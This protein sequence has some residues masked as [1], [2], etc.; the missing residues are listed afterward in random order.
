MPTDLRQNYSSGKISYSLRTRSRVIAL[1]LA[2]RAACKL[3]EFSYRLRTKDAEL[4]GNHFL[5]HSLTPQ[6][7]LSSADASVTYDVLTLSE[8]MLTYLRLKGQP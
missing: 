6:A 5:R 7:P 4:P 8:A 2:N 3:H 1:S